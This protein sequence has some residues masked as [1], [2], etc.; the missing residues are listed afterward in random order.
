MRTKYTP[1]ASLLA[2]HTIEWYPKS[3]CPL[4]SDTTSRPCRLYTIIETSASTGSENSKVVT[5]LKGFGYAGD[6]SNSFGRTKLDV[7]TLLPCQSAAILD[8]MLSSPVYENS[9]SS[10][11][12]EPSILNRMIVVSLYSNS[13]PSGRK[14]S[15]ISYSP[16]TSNCIPAILPSDL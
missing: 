1:L 15:V 8:S 14:L 11:K 10:S 9:L 16:V 3:I 12:A 2:F 7:E 13:Q 4:T 6:R 5:G